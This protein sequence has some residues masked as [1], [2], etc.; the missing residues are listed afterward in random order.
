[1]LMRFYEFADTEMV[2]DLEAALNAR[3][4]QLRNQSEIIGLRKK[5]L[6]NRDAIAKLAK[7]NRESK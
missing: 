2:E 6:A 5:A 1:M 3:K 4:K 7:R